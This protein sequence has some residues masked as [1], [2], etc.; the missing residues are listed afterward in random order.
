MKRLLYFSIT[1]AVL[2]ACNDASKKAGSDETSEETTEQTIEG[3]YG[4]TTWSVDDTYDLSSF[5]F[6][7]GDRDSLDATIT[8]EIKSVCQAK[9][10]WM[11]MDMEGMEIFVKFRDYGYF[12]PMNSTGHMATI[13]GTMYQDSISVNELQEIARDAE[14]T[15][16]EIAAIDEPEFKYS[17]IADGVIIE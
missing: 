3:R 15:D 12:V 2:F 9:G 14:K 16:E 13:K 7:L 6:I 5:L 8:G 17:F 4:D 1:A 10:C 11:K